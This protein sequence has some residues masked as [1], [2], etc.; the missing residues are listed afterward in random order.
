MSTILC[1][2]ISSSF[3]I[4][5][6]NQKVS[7]SIFSGFL[8][9][10]WTLQLHTI[11]SEKILIDQRIPQPNE[12][13]LRQDLAVAYEMK[14]MKATAEPYIFDN[15]TLELNNCLQTYLQNGNVDDVQ[16]IVDE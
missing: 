12:V 1:G 4:G 9:R 2:D 7:E 16:S 11:S 10:V 6:N 5:C 13:F 14:C 15:A 8:L 3:F